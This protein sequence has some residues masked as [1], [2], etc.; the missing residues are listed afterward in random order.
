MK[1]IQRSYHYK[2]YNAKNFLRRFAHQTRFKNSIKSILLKDNLSILD[3]GCG[4]GL[5]LNLLNDHSNYKNLTLVGFEPYMEKLEN[6]SITIYKNWEDIKEYL[7]HNPTFDY[8]TCF[9]VMEHFCIEKQRES[10]E[11]IKNIL[12]KDGVLILSVPIEI[13]IPAIIKNIIRRIDTPNSKLIYN[14]KN[15]KSSLFGTPLPEYREC[16]KYLSHMGFYFKD[17]EKV[18][19]ENFDI[20]SKFY[21][22][23]RGF[24][25][26]FNS[27]VFY[28]LKLR[29]NK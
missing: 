11:M 27:Q 9:E 6:N 1:N 20:E 24:N 19:I 7:N 2:T 5:F 15:I 13:G 4:D 10:L 26:N 25:F 16:G 22:P 18:I 3:F 8:V 17:L 28:K 21:S 12:N 23:L 29:N 14:Y